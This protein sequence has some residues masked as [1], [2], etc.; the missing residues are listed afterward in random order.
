MQQR[1][2]LRDGERYSYT[3][4]MET[5][6]IVDDERNTLRMLSQGL[7]LRGYNALTA[8]SG[9]TA[10]TQCAKT[11]VDLVLLDIRMENGMDGVQTL[12]KL[13]QQH[14]E[15]NV[16]MMS[17][18]RDIETA[19]K[20]MELGAKRYITK[21]ISIDKILASVEPF[22]EISRLSQENEVLKS[23]IGPDDEMVGE[24]QAMVNLRSQIRRVAASEPTVLITGENGSGKQLVAEAIHGQSA[25]A[26][27]PF[28]PLNCAA[29]PDELVE[30][31]LFGHERGAYTG[32]DDRRPGRFE[33]A[34]G[35]TLFLDE[36]A[37][38]SLRAQAKV[39]R[40]LESGEVERLGGHQ[41]RKVDVRILAATN[42]DLPTEIE[43]ARFRL[44]LFYR[45][46][47]IPI[48]VPPLRERREDI[49]L[50]VKYFAA[51]LQLN[52]GTSAAKV[53]DPA[54]YAVL[55]EYDWPGN[56][57]EL[58]N[59]VERLMIMVNR[60]IV[61]PAD[62][63]EVLALTPQR[64]SVQETATLYAEPYQPNTSLSTMVDAAEA[65][66]IQQ[67]LDEHDWNIRKT[68]EVLGVE[69]SNLYKKMKK[70][71]IERPDVGAVSE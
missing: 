30:N 1:R 14:P 47:V 16:V 2:R 10:L 34:N 64:Q 60:A 59:I 6:L 28:I 58:K 37:D 11:N 4:K 25:R 29:M 7:Q 62:V 50:L 24:S 67:A 36:I 32:A 8:A 35:G 12:V 61:L 46:N 17:A 9:E 20:T 65:A 21:P 15:L 22:L 69:R 53:L 19:V 13:R 70:Y 27:K 56:I 57:R 42:K 23:K 31:E 63:E 52:M 45:L 71:N 66:C 3:E 48:V 33:L 54:V 55:Q 38:M 40:V 26:K 49:P 18:Q 5:I 44:D 41:I 51:R 68:A 43:N 39:L